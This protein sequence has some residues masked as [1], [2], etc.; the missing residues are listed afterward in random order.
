MLREG[1]A[2]KPGQSGKEINR[3]PRGLKSFQ[4][5]VKS[6]KRNPQFHTSALLQLPSSMGKISKEAKN[7]SSRGFRAEDRVDNGETDMGD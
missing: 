7:Q 5:D 1:E 3:L 2:R 4:D 6:Q